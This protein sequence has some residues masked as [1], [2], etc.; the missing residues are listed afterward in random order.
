MPV[1]SYI[2]PFHMLKVWMV[3]VRYSPSSLIQL[4]SPYC[5]YF[6]FKNIGT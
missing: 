5:H 1:C 6:S 4:H 2:F 3:Q